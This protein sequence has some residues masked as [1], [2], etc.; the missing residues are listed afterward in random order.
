M[1]RR[2]LPH[3]EIPGS[4]LVCSSPKRFAADRVLH[5]LLAPRHSPYALSSLTIGM[6]ELTIALLEL[7]RFRQSL[8]H[9]TLTQKHCVFYLWIGKTTV[10]RIFSCQRPDRKTFVRRKPSHRR[11]RGSLLPCVTSAGRAL[12]APEL[13]SPLTCRGLSNLPT[14]SLRAPKSC[15]ASCAKRACPAEASR[16]AR[17][18]RGEGW[19]RI[20]GSNR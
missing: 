8:F 19:W 4:K 20:P 5:R 13:F 16:H 9:L 11:S 2:G 7:K 12:S 3:S 6:Q 14:P 10:C 15:R 18:P 1:T 17:P